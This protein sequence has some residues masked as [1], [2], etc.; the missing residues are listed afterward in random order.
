MI[1]APTRVRCLLALGMA[2]MV[3]ACAANKKLTVGAAATLVEEVAK[4]SAKQT[5]LRI[6][7]EG[8]PAYLMLLDGMV[9]AWPD[10]DRLL[11]AAAQAYASY[12]SA[13][14]EARD[15]DYALAL[16]SRARHYALKALAQ[17]GLPDAAVRPFNDFKA[18][19]KSMGR[20][21]VPYLFWTATCWGSWIKLNMDSME[22]LAELPRVELLMKKTLEL[23]EG[24]YY[25]GPHLFMGIWYA[26]RP[27][28]AGGNLDLARKHFLKAIELG[29]GK[30]LMAKVYYARYYARKVFDKKL[31]I[32]LLKEVL[33]T[34]ADRVPELTLMN[35]VAQHRAAE[36]L[37]H[38]D[39]VFE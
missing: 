21:D 36:M 5:D 39:E 30:F 31:Y 9:E 7:S 13:F 15:P 22:A 6:I 23:D 28:I 19:L 3:S 38:V 29:G 16:Y 20:R 11:L 33:N 2:V 10:N 37:Q 26:S 24:Y 18:A 35:T 12:T 14:I 25:G 27:Q 4:S 1:F 17:R 34:P 8:M 32:A